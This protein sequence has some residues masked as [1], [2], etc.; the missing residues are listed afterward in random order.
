MLTLNPVGGPGLTSWVEKHCV[1]HASQSLSRDKGWSPGFSH[2]QTYRSYLYKM[3]G[4]F[5]Q[6]QSTIPVRGLKALKISLSFKRLTPL[7]HK[8]TETN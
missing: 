4:K 7:Y 6:P 5:T 3:P 1:L 8:L 2:L